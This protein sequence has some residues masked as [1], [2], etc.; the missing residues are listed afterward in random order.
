M[1]QI[2]GNV[3]VLSAKPGVPSMTMEIVEQLD[4]AIHDELLEYFCQG[5]KPQPKDLKRIV[6][7]Y[8]S[9]SYRYDTYYVEEK[10]AAAKRQANKKESTE[11]TLPGWG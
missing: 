3:L 11:E 7:E 2:Y 5:V 8:R 4:N 10:K 6:D 9:G 1:M